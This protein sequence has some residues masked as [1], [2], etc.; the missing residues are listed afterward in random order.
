MPHMTAPLRFLPPFSACMKTLNII[1]GSD[2]IQRTRQM[3][4]KTGQCS[5]LQNLTDKNGNRIQRVYDLV[6]DQDKRL[7]I[8]T[9]GA[10][11]FYYD[12]KT[13]QSVYDPKFNA[14]TKKYK[15]I[16]CL[17]YAGD[18]HLYV[19]TYDGIRCIDLST[20]DFK[21]EEILSRHII[22]SLYED[23]QATSG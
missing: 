21:T 3:D 14:A 18:N 9:M 12:L 1:C 22:H 20:D 6:E 7:W 16:S 19:G 13:G 10:G 4:K 23:P 17:L 11:L 15:W 2:P 5:Y 8:A